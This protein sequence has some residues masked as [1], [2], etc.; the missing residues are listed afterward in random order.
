[1]KYRGSITRA[2]GGQVRN[3]RDVEEQAAVTEATAEE[4]RGEDKTSC[5]RDNHPDSTHPTPG[6]VVRQNKSSTKG[7]NPYVCSC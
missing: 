4:E 1:M 5:G 6:T 3:G 7:L 2:P